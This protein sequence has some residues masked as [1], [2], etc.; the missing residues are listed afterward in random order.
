MLPRK[1]HI[2]SELFWNVSI[3]KDGDWYRGVILLEKALQRW[4]HDE[5]IVAWLHRTLCEMGAGH[6][7]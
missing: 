2:T 4:A 6:C 1:N 3:R 7:N 5:D